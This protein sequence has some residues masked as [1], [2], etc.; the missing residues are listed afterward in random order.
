LWHQLLMVTYWLFVIYIHNSG[1]EARRM[2]TVDGERPNTIPIFGDLEPLF[3]VSVTGDPIKAFHTIEDL[4]KKEAGKFKLTA[5]KDL[6]D[7][8]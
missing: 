2:V 3:E 4:A 7:S 8:T 5:V 6:V 1:Y